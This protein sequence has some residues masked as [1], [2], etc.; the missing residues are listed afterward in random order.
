MISRTNACQINDFYVQQFYSIIQIIFQVI[1]QT[2]NKENSVIK[3]TRDHKGL[4]RKGIII[5]KNTIETISE[6]IIHTM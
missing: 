5:K 3:S 6:E 4:L 2:H 1:T